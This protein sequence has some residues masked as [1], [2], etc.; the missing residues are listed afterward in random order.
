MVLSSLKQKLNNLSLLEGVGL[1]IYYLTINYIS[2]LNANYGR[3]IFDSN[4]LNLR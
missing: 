1:F 2:I 3:I 4:D